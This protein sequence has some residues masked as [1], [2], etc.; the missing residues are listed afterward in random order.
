[1]QLLLTLETLTP[2]AWERIFGAF[3]S[4]NK[5]HWRGAPFDAVMNQLK[6]TG[7]FELV[8][9][10]MNT[11]TCRFVL[12]VLPDQHLDAALLPNPALAAPMQ[13]RLASMQQ[14]FEET[15]AESQ[16]PLGS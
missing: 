10:G 11:W 4:V 2:D 15:L 1:M 13:A 16:G 12:T 5:S 8:V 14:E 9:T 3:V 6:S 7:R